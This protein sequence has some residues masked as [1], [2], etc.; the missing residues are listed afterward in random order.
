MSEISGS[1]SKWRLVLLAVLF[2]VVLF[3]AGCGGNGGSGSTPPPPP[4]VSGVSSGTITQTGSI[5]VNGIEFDTQGATLIMDGNTSTIGTDDSVLKVGMQVEVQADFSEQGPTG[6]ANQIKVKNMVLGP[7]DE[8]QS[9]DPTVKSLQVLGQTVLVDSTSTR[10][11]GGLTFAALAAGPVV[12]VQ[13]LPRADGSIL[14]SYIEQI[15]PDLSTFLDDPT[16]SLQVKGPVSNLADT[17][18]NIYALTVDASG[19]TPLPGGLANNVTVEVKGRSYVPET[20]TLTASSI[21]VLSAGL[22]MKD[23]DLAQVEGY[24]TA[25]DT[26]YKTFVVEGQTVHYVNATMVGGIEADLG[27]DVK[28]EAEGALVNGILE[29]T[30]INFKDG[31]RV[32]ANISNVNLNA[33]TFTLEGLPGL[34]F[35]VQNGITEFMHVSGFDALKSGDWV[36]VRARVSGTSLLVSRIDLEADSP[37]TQVSLRGPVRSFDAVGERVSVLGYTVDTSTIPDTNFKINEVTV[38]ATTFFATLKTGMFVKV[39]GQ[40]GTTTSTVTWREIDIDE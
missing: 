19:I 16:H 18:F 5:F 37:S 22:G 10:L 17:T 29:A 34:V 23:T 6:K 28:I 8:V 1:F 25:L 7:I 9:L 14:A 3:L 30:K 33:N 2:G 38:G 26:A 27:I 20:T 31:V 39:N 4:T 24:I 15:A 36:K 35:T 12:K 32:E 21:E 13:G 40:L 11:E